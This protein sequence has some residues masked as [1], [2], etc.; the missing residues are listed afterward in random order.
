M[1]W[2][3]VRLSVTLVDCDHMRWNSSKIISKMVNLTFLFS[4]FPCDGTALVRP[5]VYGVT[6]GLIK[7]SWCFSF[8]F[9]FQR[10]VSELP[11]PITAKLRHMI[12]ACVY[13]INWLQKF[14]E[15]SPQKL[16]AKNMQNFGRFYTTFDF[17]REY[18]RNGSRYPKTKN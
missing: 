10:V 7:C 1:P 16:G 12:A 3:V 14:G 2:Q 15:P 9:Y 5:P 6:G 11:R 8:F 18:L 4:P 13:F 17:D